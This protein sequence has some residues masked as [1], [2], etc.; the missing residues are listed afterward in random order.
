M[1]IEAD[2][3]THTVASGHAYSTVSELALA[4]AEKGLKMIAITDHGPAM[5]GGPHLYHFSNLKILPDYL[6]DVRILQGVE[7][8]ISS[9]GEI[10]LPEE[11]LKQLDFVTAGIHAHANYDN[12]DMEEHTAATIAAMK[13][14][15]V[16]MITHP[17]N[18]YFPVDMEAV[19]E[20]AAK[21]KVI[22]ELNA[23]SFDRFRYGKRGDVGKVLEMCRLA[24]EYGVPL[25]LNSD[26]HFHLDVGN[27]E[28]L[29]EIID[30]AGLRKEDVLNTSA[31]AVER[32]L[33]EK[34]TVQ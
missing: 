6:H 4:A 17:E 20:A 21:Y 33:A 30:K 25:C 19:V 31:E 10:D 23:S 22:L 15:R 7:A 32:F 18:A 5:P 1:K 9:D 12:T 34:K 14:P 28:P 27:I 8:N 11:I 29:A 26:A 3:H 13:N 24:R 2:L 16:M